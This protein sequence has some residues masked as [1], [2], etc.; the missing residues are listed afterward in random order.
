LIKVHTRVLDSDPLFLHK[1]AA[2]YQRPAFLYQDDHQRKQYHG[3]NNGPLAPPPPPP[4]N[5][6]AV[7]LSTVVGVAVVDAVPVSHSF[8]P[9]LL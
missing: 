8:A 5:A 2:H 4:K 1:G 3:T 6:I 9:V 7:S